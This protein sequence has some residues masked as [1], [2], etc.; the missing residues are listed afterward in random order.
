[1]ANS[2]IVLGGKTLIDLT[3]DTVKA[4]NLLVGNTAHGSDGELIQGTCD[5]DAN[6]TVA[7]ERTPTSSEILSGKDAWANG[8]EVVGSM[9]NM[10]KQTGTISS[11]DGAYTIPLGYHDGTGTVGIAQTE[12]DKLISANIRANVTILG[13]V[14]SMQGTEGVDA[15]AKEVT[16]TLDGFEV[17]PDSPNYNYLSS[18]V[19]KPIP[20]SYTANAGGGTT[21]T[22][23]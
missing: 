23:A 13:V 20:V 12:K 22:I 19:V 5:F 10:G 16:P 8:N 2:K 15:Q 6:T 11:K 3:A 7:P 9:P 21:V 14:G 18:V 4:K 17:L 1:M